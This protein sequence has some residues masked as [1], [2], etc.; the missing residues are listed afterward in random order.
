MQG[1]TKS[2][3]VKN[4]PAPMVGRG[5]ETHLNLT[6]DKQKGL[7]WS[8]TNPEQTAQLAGDLRETSCNQY[9]S[10]KTLQKYSRL[11]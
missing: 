1:V 8:P 3:K 9:E 2:G 4:T 6:E 7:M 10:T 5:G 11:T